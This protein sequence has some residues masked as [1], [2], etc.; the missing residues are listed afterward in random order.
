MS[1]QAL[2]N[3]YDLRWH[4]IREL[5]N[6][7]LKKKY[8]HIQTAHIKAIGIDETHV[9]K[10]MQNQQ[11]LTIVSDLQSGAVIHEGEDKGIS[12]LAGL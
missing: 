9:G 3:F 6:K 1:I 11:Y 12:A 2:A 10:G 7:Q 4:T 5:E 8:S